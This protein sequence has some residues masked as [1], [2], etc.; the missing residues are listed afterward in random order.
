MR[1]RFWIHLVALASVLLHTA[2][3]VYHHQVMLGARFER[4]HLL[5]SLA[6]SC[7]GTGQTTLP[8]AELPWIPAPSEQSSGCLIC[9][10][11]ISALALAPQVSLDAPCDVAVATRPLPPYQARLV[12]IT[13]IRPPVRGPPQLI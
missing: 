10:G 7:H 4:Q 9:K 8:D 2:A 11:L 3:V 12:Q 5:S 1:R 13:D 6:V